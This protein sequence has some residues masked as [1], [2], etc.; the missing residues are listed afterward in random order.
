MLIT[1]G[2]SVIICALVSKSCPDKKELT[3]F[4]FQPHEKVSV[5]LFTLQLCA[6]RSGLFFCCLTVIRGFSKK[7]NLRSR[8]WVLKNFFPIFMKIFCSP[9]SLPNKWKKNWA[10]I[11]LD[12]ANSI[13]RKCCVNDVNVDVRSSSSSR[14]LIICNDQPIWCVKVINDSFQEWLLNVINLNNT[15]QCVN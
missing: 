13:E 8:L 6:R 12:Y 15:S 9:L 5:Y 7:A 14:T 1:N 4:S 10:N 2:K 11:S 3:K